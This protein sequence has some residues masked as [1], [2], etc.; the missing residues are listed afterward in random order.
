LRVERQQPLADR[1]VERP[2]LR[3]VVED[4]NPPIL[5]FSPMRFTFAFLRF[6][7]FPLEAG[8]DGV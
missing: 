5:A 2:G 3:A 7:T 8:D 1:L 6:G 4:V